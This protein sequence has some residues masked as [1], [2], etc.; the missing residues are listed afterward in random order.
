MRSDQQSTVSPILVLLLVLLLL[1]LSNGRS[2]PDTTPE[3]APQFM[4]LIVEETSARTPQLAD[5]VLSAEL[6]DVVSSL[7]HRFRLVD[8]N[9]VEWNGTPARVLGPWRELPAL[10]SG[11]SRGLPW[12]LFVLPDGRVLYEG[13]L[14]SSVDGVVDLVRKHTK[15]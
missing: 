4:V 13:P 8:Q 12:L 3:T 7:G 10:S 6:R 5:L 15:R 2:R 9:A 1:T 11:Q 14:P